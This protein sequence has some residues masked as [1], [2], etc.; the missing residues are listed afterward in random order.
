MISNTR[1]Y[2]FRWVYL[3]VRSLEKHITDEAVHSWAHK[4]PRNLTEAYDQLW[5][6]MR[7]YDDFDVDLAERAIMWVLCSIEPLESGAF[8]EAIRYAVQGST[9]IRKK[10]QTQ[11]QI[12]SLCQDLLTIDEARDVWMLPHASVAEYFESRGYT[13]WKCDAFASKVC[14]GVLEN[15]QPDEIGY[16]DGSFAYYVTEHWS[17]HV[18]Q[19]DQWLG[20]MEGNNEATKA[21]Q[22]LTEA[23]ERFLGSPTESSAKYREWAGS[24]FLSSEFEPTNMSLFA[25][26][27][28]GLWYTLRDWWLHSKMTMEMA[29]TKN[30]NSDTSL[31][32]AAKSNCLPACRRL[33]DLIEVMSPGA[34]RNCVMALNSAIAEERFDIVQF[35]LMEAKVDVNLSD[36]GFSGITAAHVAA[37]FSSATL[38]WMLDQGIVDVERENDASHKF[39]NVLIAAANYQNIGSVQILLKVGANTN[40]AVHKGEYGSALVAAVDNRN[41]AIVRLLLEHGADP[42]LP[43]K[44]GKYGSALEASMIQKWDDNTKGKRREEIQHM[45]LYAGADPAAV[46]ERGEYGSPLAAAAFWGRKEI[47][48]VMV[49]RAGADVAINILQQSRRPHVRYFE[50]EKAVQEWKDTATYLGQMGVSKET[51]HNIGLW[52][53]IE[54]ESCNLY[55]MGKYMLDYSKLARPLR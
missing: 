39:G 45:L 43:M 24:V 35:F 32:L 41:P 38:Q 14:L 51:L 29:F 27:R 19:Y 33:V 1:N 15:F 54:P 6:N 23:L 53:N 47:L 55:Y 17:D 40:A 37:G 30:G 16:K 7:G 26:C 50:D 44:G 52:E 31:S 3:Q 4:L 34:A 2:R 8:L 48:R 18:R 46:L 21:D 13:N 36:R 9:V 42:N 5:D 20:T 11:Q 49:D 22:N 28:Y 25:V 12:L 10:E